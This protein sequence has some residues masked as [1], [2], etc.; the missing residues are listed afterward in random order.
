ML[1]LAIRAFAA[2]G[3]PVP[4]VAVEAA[5]NVAVS[6]PLAFEPYFVMAQVAASAGRTEE[7][8]A[9]MLEALTRR[10]NHMLV[11]LHMAMLSAQAGQGAEAFRHLNFLLRYAPNA[12]PLVLPE[13]AKALRNE[14]ARREVARLLAAEPGWR[15]DF[16][17]TAQNAG[18]R[19]ADARSLLDMVR[20][21]KGANGDVGPER[22]LYLHSLVQAGDVAQA[23]ALWLQERSGGAPPADAYLTNGRFVPQPRP[24]LFDWTLHDGSAGR[25]ELVAGGK[26][27]GELHAQYF[28]GQNMLLAEQLLALRPGRYRLQYTGRSEGGEGRGRLFWI[29]SCRTAQ[30][31]LARAEIVGL[32]PR[33][34]G[35]AAV[36]TVPGN[37]PGQ[38]L[39]L[40]AETGDVAG[41]VDLYLSELQVVPA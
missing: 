24:S 8:R 41:T 7:A 20:G 34:S 16:L 40:V 6:S 31:Q 13:L 12:H 33:P 15:G 17:R 39:Q 25:A 19:P 22:D 35:A 36:F 2:P 27:A 21:F 23:R 18:V 1:R 29:V 10:P 37:C 30:G 38:L 5:R 26:D 4:P 28:G 9:L 14:E 32:G 3:A 11:R